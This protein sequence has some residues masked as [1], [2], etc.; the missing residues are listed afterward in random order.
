MN[1]RKALGLGR[2]PFF[3]P[4][5]PGGSGAA[6]RPAAPQREQSHTVFIFLV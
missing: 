4:P 1:F 2:I 6:S 3:G 5:L